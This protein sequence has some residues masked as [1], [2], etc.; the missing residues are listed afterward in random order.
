[1]PFG[2]GLVSHLQ[3]EK[4]AQISVYVESRIKLT[5]RVVFYIVDELKQRIMYVCMSIIENS[6]IKADD[7]MTISTEMSLK[8]ELND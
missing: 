6:N 8:T 4:Q 2:F 5:F 1:M 3:P 7:I